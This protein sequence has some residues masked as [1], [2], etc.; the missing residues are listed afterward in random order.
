MIPR[1][2]ALTEPSREVDAR[3]WA[4]FAGVKYIGHNPAYASH[5][6]ENPLTQVEFTTPPK[7]TRMVTNGPRYP[8]ATPVTASLDAAVALVAKVL[9]GWHADVDVC[10]PPP[11]SDTFGAR[12]FN[13]NGDWQN[14]AGEGPTSAIALLVAL[15][16]ALEPRT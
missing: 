13:Q 16:T 3:I 5:G 15:F 1:L 6:R 4:F 10:S 7:R 8:H 11:M 14:Y 2:K 9:P 12:L